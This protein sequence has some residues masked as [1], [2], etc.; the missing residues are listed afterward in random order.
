MMGKHHQEMVIA[1]LSQY[2]QRQERYQVKVI[3]GVVE[4][5]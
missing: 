4:V 3:V 2:Q 1:H 5:A